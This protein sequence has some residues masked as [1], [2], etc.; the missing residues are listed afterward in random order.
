MASILR[1]RRS[2]FQPWNYPYRKCDVRRHR[3]AVEQFT[4]STQRGSNREIGYSATWRRGALSEVDVSDRTDRTDT[5][6][7]RYRPTAARPGYCNSSITSVSRLVCCL[8]ASFAGIR[9]VQA[10]VKIGQGRAGR[11]ISDVGNGG[12]VEDQRQKIGFE[13]VAF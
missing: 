5:A 13:C 8:V 9:R 11:V 2:S 4:R 1:N 3:A 6:W 12:G 7:T 10:D